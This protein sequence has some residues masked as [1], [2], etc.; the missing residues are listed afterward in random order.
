MHNLV[1]LVH[2]VCCV[3][4]GAREGKREVKVGVRKGEGGGKAKGG[5]SV[6]LVLILQLKRF[7][8]KLSKST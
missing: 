2:Q 7:V 5:E 3:S 1:D 6:P 8:D 4:V